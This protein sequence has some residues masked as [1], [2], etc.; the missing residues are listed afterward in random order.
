VHEDRGLEDM[1]G[2]LETLAVA[3]YRRDDQRGKSYAPFVVPSLALLFT[4]AVVVWILHRRR[5]RARFMLDR[6][7]KESLPS[8]GN[9]I[10]LSLTSRWENSGGVE[11]LAYFEKRAEDHVLKVA[12]IDSFDAGDTRSRRHSPTEDAIRRSDEFRQTVITLEAPE[13]SVHEMCMMP[14]S[15]AVGT[16]PVVGKLR[17]L[18]VGE[19]ALD[20]R[21]KFY[22][23]DEQELRGFLNEEARRLLS[24]MSGFVMEAR[25]CAIVLYTPQGLMPLAELET[26]LAFMYVVL[27]KN[28]NPPCPP[29]KRQTKL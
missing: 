3:G 24:A 12:D 16:V 7:F 26:A 10:D 5:A 21:F 4:V 1:T 14:K 11:H 18:K 22:A 8:L 6:G 25:G 28:P 27:S 9:G 15:L 29:E 23:S 17:P 13:L 19:A 20:R 2:Y